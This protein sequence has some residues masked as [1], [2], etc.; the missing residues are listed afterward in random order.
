[1]LAPPADGSRAPGTCSAGCE[2]GDGPFKASVRDCFRRVVV[3]L[4]M[5][6]CC[7]VGDVSERDV[8]SDEDARA[9]DVGS[10]EGGGC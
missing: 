2:G 1:M 8:G 6:G 4:E 9:R 10:D 3:S 5:G 7:G